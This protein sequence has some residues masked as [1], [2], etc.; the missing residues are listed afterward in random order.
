LPEIVLLVLL[1]NGACGVRYTSARIR[2]NIRWVALLTGLFVIGFRNS[3]PL[4]LVDMNKF[5]K[6]A[7]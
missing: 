1:V 7:F 3:H 2:K 4:T 5:I 6:V